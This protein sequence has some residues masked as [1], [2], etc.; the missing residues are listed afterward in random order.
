MFFGVCTTLVNIVVYWLLA[1]V[2]KV[3]V[4]PSTIIAWVIAVLFAY[5]TNRKWVFH[6]KVDEIRDSIK[7]MAAFFGCRFATGVLDWLC[8]FVFVTKL[9]W[10]DISI[11]VISNVMVIILNYVA[12]KFLIFKKEKQS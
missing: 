12:S 1:H 4:M 11:K 6:S 9:G 3:G 5:I 7:E 10:N 2:T 8:M